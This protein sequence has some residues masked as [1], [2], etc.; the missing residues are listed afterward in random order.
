MDIEALKT[1]MK[2][3]DEA[4]RLLEG[5]P[6]NYTLDQLLA[7]YELLMDRFAPHRVGDYVELARAPAISPESGWHSSRH[8]L[9][10]GAKGVIRTAECGDKGFRFGVAFNN[11]SWLDNNG[12]PQTVQRESI[13][14]FSE[15]WLR[16]PKD[17]GPR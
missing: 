4:R 12:Q 5:G 8:F 14:T 15:E 6:M 2:K 17:S 9:T 3:M 10:E 11:E 16:R 13:Y 1:A 7:S